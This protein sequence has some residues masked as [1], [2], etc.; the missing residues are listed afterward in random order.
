VT[1]VLKVARE[2][3]VY[4]EPIDAIEAFAP[5]AC[6]FLIEAPSSKRTQLEQLLQSREGHTG[7]PRPLP[8]E[9]RRHAWPCLT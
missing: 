7:K 2:G 5:V 4:A 9:A 6:A 8:N 1:N 3:A